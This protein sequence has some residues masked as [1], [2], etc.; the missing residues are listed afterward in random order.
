MSA[1]PTTQAPSSNQTR[2]E[3]AA[4]PA[5]PAGPR[6]RLRLGRLIALAL[7]I[8]LIALGLPTAM[9][10]VEYRRSHSITDDAF[11]EAHL[12]NI[13]PEMVSGRI[14]RFLAEEND[15]VE[16]GQ[17][18]AEVDPIPY[19]DKVN[20]ARAQLDSARAELARQ[21]ADLDRVRKEVPIQ[22]EI[23]RRTFAAALADRAKARR[24][25]TTRSASWNCWSRSKNKP[26]SRPAGRWNLRRTTWPIRRSEPR[27]PA[28]W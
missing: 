4:A 20:V 11:V 18:V 6:H 16:Q 25:A 28:W 9:S 22:I 21:S 10:W 24:P 26:S 15:R 17:V 12:V 13:A 7:L 8:A 19:R 23:A 3:A 27:S 1:S 2:P 5:P 14:I